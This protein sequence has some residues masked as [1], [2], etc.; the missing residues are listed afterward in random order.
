MKKILYSLILLVSTIGLQSCLHDN[1]D[2]FS[3]SASERLANTVKQ[4]RAILESASNGWLL[5]YFAGENY[6]NGGYN[7]LL[8]FKDGE[9]TASGEISEDDLTYSSNY[10][11]ITDQG[12]V[13][14]FN[15]YNELLHYLAQPYQDNVEGVQGD[16][17]F[18]IEKA[19]QDTVLLKGKKWGNTMRL[20]RMKDN[21]SWKNYLDKMA[22]MADSIDWSTYNY[23]VNGDS[24]AKLSIDMPNRQMTITNGTDVSSMGFIV[25]DYG[26]RLGDSISV[27]G[28]SVRE[29]KWDGTTKS[30]TDVNPDSK[31]SLH[32]YYPLG[33]H[34][35]NDYA[36]TYTFSVNPKS[37]QSFTIVL[38][39]NSTKTGLIGVPQDDA[40]P[41]QILFDYSQTT[42]KITLGFQKLTD[43]TYNGS[44][45]GLYL[46]P[47]DLPDGT[48]TWD[49]SVGMEGLMLSNG[50]VSFSDNGAFGSNS[51]NSFLIVGFSGA[52][53][54]STYSQ[55]VTGLFK[56]YRIRYFNGLIKVQQ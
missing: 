46:C 48:F 25:T 24:V 22:E 21:V 30:F 51:C 13:L 54:N 6:Q 55:D 50:S 35:I 3:E 18:V 41:Y 7:F 34:S 40:F 12:P 53:S 1:E 5:Q 37:G 29:L 38:T 56:S 49:P 39:P 27:N 14:T 16:Y 20:I 43:Y 9:V 47:W 8:K 33:Y 52:P 11:I 32:Y 10:D 31:V 17:E 23:S 19:S 4:E 44:V 2:K 15:T 36:G 45:Y 42:G 26:I 28:T